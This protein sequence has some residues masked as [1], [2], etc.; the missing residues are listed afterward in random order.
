VALLLLGLVGCA[1]PDPAAVADRFDWPDRWDLV[2]ETEDRDRSCGEV[3]CPTVIRYYRAADEPAQVCEDAAAALGTDTSVHA[4]G[5]TLD[6]CVDDVFVT[7]SVSD[8]GQ[9]VHEG[10]ED[11]IVEAPTSGAAVAV[12]AR[13]GC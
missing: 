2:L 13:V 5:C 12:R 8:E 9:R 10:V 7:V 1:S 4:R 11:R 3:L 6:R